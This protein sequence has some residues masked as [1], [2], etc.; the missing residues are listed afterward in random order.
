MFKLTLA[1]VETMLY[2]FGSQSNDASSLCA[3]LIP[4]SDG[5]FYGTAPAGGANGVG[6]VFEIVPE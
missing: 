3:G 4:E 5:N 6:T 2:S 1:G